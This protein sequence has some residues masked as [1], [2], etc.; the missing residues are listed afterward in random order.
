MCSFAE[1]NLAKVEIC[2]NLQ[3]NHRIGKQ[4]FL[5]VMELLSNAHHMRQ[6]DFGDLPQI[7]KYSI[8]NGLIC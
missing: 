3:K 6:I 4:T 1:Y 8:Q 5:V 2:T 7:W